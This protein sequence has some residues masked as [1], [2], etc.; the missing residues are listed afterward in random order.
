MSIT[1]NGYILRGEWTFCA[2]GDYAFAEKMG[3]K[4]FLKRLPSPKYPV[5]RSD[6]TPRSYDHIL[7]ECR[8]FEAN[9]KKIVNDL[10][11]AAKSCP[12]LIVPLDFFRDQASYYLVSEMITDTK[13]KPEE[14]TALNDA[15][16]KGLILQYAKALS[17]LQAVKI[18]HGDLKPS[19][20]FV[21]RTS[22]GISLKVM[23]F[24][25]CY[26]SEHPPACEATMGSMEY[27]SPELGSYICEEDPDRGNIVTCTSDIFAAGLMI[28]QYV[29]GKEVGKDCRYAF[30]ADEDSELKLSRMPDEFKEL[31]S[32]MLRINREERLDTAKFLKAAEDL[33]AGR[34]PRYDDS[35]VEG[36]ILIEEPDGTFTYI[37]SDGS[38]SKFAKTTA[39]ILSKVK[40]IPIK[41]IK[42]VPP[43]PV[44]DPIPD[45]VPDPVPDPVPVPPDKAVVISRTDTKV[46]LRMPDGSTSIM[47]TN[48]YDSLH[49]KGKI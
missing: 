40:K 48:M 12:S 45:S 25:D 36:P 23:D 39:V 32:H 9:K 31:I 29:C 47:S 21:C 37:G 22:S 6:F 7:E 16:K 26:Y 8:K 44:P 10:H 13:L 14:I 49:K 20:V 2:N 17:A 1:V 19:N 34:K 4:Y 30:Q 42:D 28:H 27:Y 38:R 41:W 3:K 5:K 24:D 46:T 43:D 33:A 15:Q 11:E 18:V 35:A